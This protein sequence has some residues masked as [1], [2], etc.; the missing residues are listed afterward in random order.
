MGRPN[1]FDVN[2]MLSLRKVGW[3]ITRLAQAYNV[4]HTTIIYH[5]QKHNVK[6]E[7]D[8][9]I[10][11]DRPEKI[12]KGKKERVRIVYVEVP[13]KKKEQKPD[14]PSKYAHLL[15]DHTRPAK[16]YK[17]Y[18]K[19]EKSRPKDKTIRPWI[20]N[21]M[22]FTHVERVKRKPQAVSIRARRPKEAVTM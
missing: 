13:A 6:P 18:I 15:D 9:R 10:S 12:P 11:I 17:D 22:G 14:L 2:E 1:K 21:Y 3:T 16:S 8:A 20:K 19:D 5:C 4:D 7:T